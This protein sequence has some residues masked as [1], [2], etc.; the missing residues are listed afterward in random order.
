MV[1]GFGATAGQQ[2]GDHPVT[3]V[4]LQGQ[5]VK[6]PKQRRRLPGP[7]EAGRRA[8][9]PVG[10]HPAGSL[11]GDLVT[12][13]HAVPDRHAPM[14]AASAEAGKGRLCTTFCPTG[15]SGPKHGIP[16]FLDRI[17]ASCRKKGAR[18]CQNT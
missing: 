14:M 18:V 16:A 1:F 4:A 13:R 15:Q 10:S 5:N 2:V 3:D 9:R 12:I 17:I 8:K 11:F 7:V 6:R